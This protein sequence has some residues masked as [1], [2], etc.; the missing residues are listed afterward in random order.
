MV[1]SQ[2]IDLSFS[3]QVQNKLVGLIED[4]LIFLTQRGELVHVK[5]SSIVDVI[6]GHSPE[7]EAI[8]LR[9]NELVK[10]IE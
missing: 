6:G 1:Y 3:Q 9:F 7:G 4:V 8:R 10:S 5:K 2:A